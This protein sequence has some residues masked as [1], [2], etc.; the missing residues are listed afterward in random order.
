MF[1]ERPRPYPEKIII[2]ITPSVVLRYP[3][4]LVSHR[5][6]VVKFQRSLCDAYSTSDGFWK[7]FV[8]LQVG[9]ISY[10]YGFILAKDLAVSIYKKE[11]IT[12][13]FRA[14]P[15][16]IGYLLT[17]DILNYVIPNY[18]TPKVQRCG[19]LLTNRVIDYDLFGVRSHFIQR[20]R[21]SI[22]SASDDNLQGQL[23]E[24]YLEE[25]KKSKNEIITS[26]IIEIL[27][28]PLLTVISRL[29]IYD[30]C[31][32]V[33]VPKLTRHILAVDGFFSLYQGF[34]P[35][36]LGKAVACA[37]KTFNKF[38]QKSLMSDQEYN[39]TFEQ[40]F[41]VI[42]TIASAVAQQLSL[43]KR[44]GSQIDGFCIQ[45]TYFNLLSQMPWL[46]IALQLAVTIGLLHLKDQ[47]LHEHIM[48][49]IDRELR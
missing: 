1:G 36:L 7:E 21:S 44:C 17:K 31:V 12:G 28:Y 42:L 22:I 41:P 6:A 24:F 32:R 11:G 48:N 4:L 3:V 35:H 39:S 23:F 26:V 29:I 2:T 13:F 43:V 49:T 45:E 8:A 25:I 15:E 20:Y 9:G 33:N 30:G 34:V 27:T 46:N 19:S 38:I 16:Y 40:M 18:I 37:S 14:F 47:L 5:L 10:A